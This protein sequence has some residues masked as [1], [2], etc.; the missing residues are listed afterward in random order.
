MPRALTCV[1]I[2]ILFLALSIYMAA[3][4]FYTK[5]MK[6]ADQIY[7]YTNAEIRHRS[8]CRTAKMITPVWGFTLGFIAIYLAYTTTL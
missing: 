6:G 7:G 4:F 2:F 8:I 3:I 5:A 1:L